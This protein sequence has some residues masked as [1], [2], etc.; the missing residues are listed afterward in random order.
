MNF[1]FFWDIKAG[2]LLIAP[3]DDAG[4]SVL[5]VDW[6]HDE[7]YETIGVAAPKAQADGGG[8]LLGCAIARLRQNHACAVGR[9]QC[10]RHPQ[11]H[12]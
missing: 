5:S 12:S 6:M 7:G 11:Q 3:L 2:C 9:H 10:P 8:R 1:N 4:I